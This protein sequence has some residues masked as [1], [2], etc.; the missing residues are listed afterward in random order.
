M[1]FGKL[2]SQR[3]VPEWSDRYI[4]Y[5]MMKGQLKSISAARESYL[6][7]FEKLKGPDPS[8]I[9][10]EAFQE[11]P[12]TVENMKEDRE[13]Y[14]LLEEDLETVERFYLDQLVAAHKRF[15]Q[16]LQHCIKMELLEEYTPQAYPLLHDHKFER[17][18]DINPTVFG[19]ATEEDATVVAEEEEQSQDNIDKS[20]RRSST[21][22]TGKS[23]KRGLA[24]SQQQQQN[25]Y[26][27]GQMSRKSSKQQRQFGA[28]VIPTRSVSFARSGVDPDSDG[29]VEIELSELSDGRKRSSVS[30]RGSVEE[31]VEQ[32][33]NDVHVVA[34]DEWA[35]DKLEDDIDFESDNAGG[36]Q[37]EG[38]ATSPLGTRLIQMERKRSAAA[39]AAAEASTSRK[40]STT[41]TSSAAGCET[42]QRAFRT[43][44][45]SPV[46]KTRE[47]RRDLRRLRR[48]RILY[49]VRV[50]RRL[51]LKKM[52]TRTKATAYD[53]QD[54][55]AAQGEGAAAC[56]G[57]DTAPA[58]TE[59]VITVRMSLDDRTAKTLR[60]FADKDTSPQRG[61][62]EIVVFPNN[63]MVFTKSTIRHHRKSLVEAFKEFYRGLCLLENFCK[64]NLSGFDKVMKKHDKLTGTTTRLLYIKR[65]KAQHRF[66]DMRHLLIIKA[67]T[68]RVFS[69]CFTE[70]S[71]QKA[72][73][74]LRIPFWQK[75]KLGWSTFR[76][77]LLL[78]ITMIFIYLG[79]KD[80]S[81]LD[82]KRAD[83]VF[84]MFRGM[85][86]LIILNWCWGIDMYTWTKYRV[87]YA[88]I[89]LFD[90]RSHISWQ[91]VMESAAVFTVAW[92]L[93][94]VCYLLSAI[95]PVPLE[96][97]DD[98]PYQVFPGC[99]GLLVVLV[100][101]VQQSTCK[102]WLIRRLT[103]LVRLAPEIIRVYKIIVS[104][105][106]GV[107]NFVDIY[108]ASQLTSLVIFLQDV[109]FSV[110]F[111][112]SD[113]WT[114]D[115]ICMRSR[116]YAMPLIAAIPFVLRFLQC[117]R[118]FIG[119][120]ERWHIVNGGKYLSSLA[121]I[122]CSFFLYFFGHLALLA[123]WIVAVVVSVGYN[124]YFDVRYDWGL[125][126]VKSS[127][128][129]LRN[130]LIFPRWWYYVAIALNLLGRCSWALTVSA[131]FFPTTNMIFSTIIATSCEGDWAT[132]SASK[133]SNCPTR[134]CAGRRATSR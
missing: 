45:L 15:Y 96:W 134:K 114:G 91:Q 2:L 55:P 51:R 74:K 35:D 112:V 108:L 78:M 37:I 68:E 26:R 110:C 61:K 34:E 107:D 131:S 79:A 71:R 47:H 48:E 62:N 63:N 66:A 27:S 36:G 56:E 20:S 49:G 89:F 104:P 122:I 17:M 120:R 8:D 76:L 5:K 105:V 33:I 43:T 53:F 67:E 130:K 106:V 116:P 44:P 82:H 88:L 50:L 127:N 72:M 101:L 1:K 24:Q 85:W 7:A 95:S 123:P 30:S 41:T 80:N 38:Q 57:S 60:E 84:I 19:D 70:G 13:L 11:M 111:F 100:M 54:D 10:G 28:G 59:D 64:L 14:D 6:H 75:K 65:I 58:E 86:L 16:L 87:S 32:D 115:D 25:M 118:K 31:E 21:G 132:F 113:A 83:D 69:E 90:M 92:L 52:I 40:P 73:K 18:G 109:Q 12:L 128:W 102:Y 93:F 77:V 42:K 133:T 39:A 117:L 22:S 81:G 98:I 9:A 3:M 125:L 124:F 29:M 103:D 126:D 99:L 121:V 4:R 119:S 46:E 23:K 94:V 129:L 97:M